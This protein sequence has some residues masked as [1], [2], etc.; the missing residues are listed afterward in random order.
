M[1]N[2][3]YERMQNYLIKNI[4]QVFSR[5]INTRRSGN[6]RDYI[7]RSQKFDCLFKIKKIFDFLKYSFFISFLFPNLIVM[8]TGRKISMI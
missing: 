5:N 7:F 2:L 8:L 6:T 3:T 4:Y 1:K